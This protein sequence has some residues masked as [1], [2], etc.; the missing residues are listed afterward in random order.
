MQKQYKMVVVWMLIICFLLTSMNTITVHRFAITATTSA[1]ATQSI[2]STNKNDLSNISS[3]LKQYPARQLGRDATQQAELHASMLGK[4]LRAIPKKSQSK[5][6]LINISNQWMHIYQDGKQI[7]NTPITTG[8]PGLDTPIGTFHVFNKQ[9][10]TTFYSMW[11]PG[12]SNYFAPTHINFALEFLYPG[13][14]IHDSLWRHDYGPGSNGPH[15]VPGY[16]FESGS[17]G[18][19][20]VPYST[21]NWLYSWADVNTAVQLA[22]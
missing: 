17:H 20:N 11:S 15:Y 6:I 1:H 16:G 14:F 13:Y 10:P 8:R 7:A 5:V 19:V 4:N 9:S 2:T 21:M 12:S 22:Y 18:C 3:N